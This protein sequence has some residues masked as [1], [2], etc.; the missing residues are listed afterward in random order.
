MKLINGPCSCRFYK[1]HERN[2]SGIS[3][4]PILCQSSLSIWVRGWSR[5]VAFWMTIYFASPCLLLELDTTVNLESS[6][7]QLQVLFIWCLIETKSNLNFG[8]NDVPWFCYFH[9]QCFNIKTFIRAFSIRP[10]NIAIVSPAFSVSI[11]CEF[12]HRESIGKDMEAFLRKDR[13]SQT[14]E[15]SFAFHTIQDIHKSWKI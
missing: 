4:P 8:K 10:I 9:F 2:K 7:L 5:V 13:Y 1:S 3:E 12:E 15:M 6:S 14:D 11:S